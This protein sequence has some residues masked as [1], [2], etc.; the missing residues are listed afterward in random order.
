MLRKALP[1]LFLLFASLPLQAQFFLN[2]EDPGHLRWST[3]ESAHYQLIYPEGSDSLAR[4]YARLLEQFR[5]PLGRS[6]GQTPGQGLRRKMPVVLHTHNPYSNG[7][8]SWAPMRFDLYTLPE[9]HGSDPTPWEIQLISHEP[10]HQAQLQKA[11]TGYFGVF[12]KLFGEAWNPAGYQLFL[13]FALGEGDAVTAETGLWPASRARTAD[14]LNYYRVAL[15]QGDT[16]DWFRW[17]YGSYKHYTPDYYKVGYLTVAGARYLSGNPFLMQETANLA[18]RKPYLL[19]SAFRSTVRQNRQ[20]ERF[21][22]TFQTILDSV[23]AHWQADAARR[24]PFLELEALT[25]PGA[26]PLQYSSPQLD[27]NG[28]LYALREGYM[29]PPQLVSIRNGQV[30]PLKYIN[31]T[32]THLRYERQRNRLYWTEVRQDPRW[33]QSGTSA[34]V[35]YDINRGKAR[36]LTRGHRYYNPQP[37]ADGE[38]LAVAE[39]GTEGD[40]YAVVLSADDGTPLSRTRMPDGF[41][42]CEFAWYGTALYLSALSV[43]GYGIYRLSPAGDWEEVLSPTYQKLSRLSAEESCLQWVSD[44]SGVNEIY[45]YFPAD[46]R[47]VQLTQT[48]YG[49]TDPC[50]DGDYLYGV[51]QTLEGQMICRIPRGKLRPREVSFAPDSRYLLADAVTRQEASLGPGVDLEAAVPLGKPRHYAK[52]AHPLRLH[53]WLPLYVNYDAVKEGTMDLSYNVASLG[54]SG[55]FQNTLGTVYGMVGYALHPSPDYAGHWRNALHA[56]LVYKGLY[57]VFEASVDLGDRCA[58]QYFINRYSNGGYENQSLGRMLRQAPL[59]EGSLRVYLPLSWRR[60]GLSYGV[61]PQVKYSVGNNWLATEPIWWKVNYFRG[62]PTHY[63][64]DRIGDGT[65]TLMQRLHLSLRAY[66]MLSK[67]PNHVYPFLGIGGDLGFS[68]RPGLEK[69]FTPNLYGYLYGYLPGL[70]EGQG[71]KLTAML[72]RQ[73]ASDDA[74]LFRE[75]SADTLPRGFDASAGPY[76]AQGSPLQWKITADYAIPVYLGDLNIPGI[77]YIKNFLIT[78]HGDYCGLQDGNLWSAGADLTAEMAKF[79][80]PFKS[81]LGVSLSYLGGSWYEHTQQSR[82]LSAQLIFGVNF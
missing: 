41:Q 6:Y 45:R 63:R 32:G 9:A 73:L 23:N 34:V 52:L 29:Q 59:A 1:L 68:F 56:K 5:L 16:R 12:N 54:L 81:S 10:R 75:L 71:L 55:Y 13:G 64:I 53:S 30:F 39:Y 4:R 15:D 31:G 2:G 3:L 74:L 49:I 47:L 42:P 79:I 37:S 44:R 17:R 70:W 25:R 82:R 80:L 35:Y 19:S 27:D 61:V 62:L 46:A 67:A 66:A 76:I 33:K 43:D 20:G 28:T 77:A 36:D 22:D 50:E 72:Q 69:I 57:P 48:R 7:S 38:R 24:A 26:Y 65:S 21:E 14:F 51:S 60:L 78:P 11:G 8:V 18:R 40:Q 58:Q